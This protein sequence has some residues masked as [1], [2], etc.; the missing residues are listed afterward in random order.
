MLKT[1]EIES[2]RGLEK[3]EIQNL[4]R[5]N[6]ITGGNNFGKTSVL[7]ALY[8][9]LATP[10]QLNR[11]PRVFRNFQDSAQEQFSHYWLWLLPDRDRNRQAIVRASTPVAGKFCSTLSSKAIE[12]TTLDYRTERSIVIPNNVLLTATRNG[13]LGLHGFSLGGIEF[14]PSPIAHEGKKAFRIGPEGFQS[15]LAV[16]ADW[17]KKPDEEA[18]KYNGVVVSGGE[19]KLVELLRCV[20]PRLK[21]LRYAKITQQALIYADIGIRT[22]VLIPT[23]Q[24]GQ[25]FE[26]L[27]TLFIEM[28]TVKPKIVIIDE[29]ENGLHSS[30]Y[31]AVWLGIAQLA[32]SLDIQVF[33]TTHSKEC[34]H[35][36]HKASQTEDN[37]GFSNHRLRVESGKLI[38]RSSPHIL[39]MEI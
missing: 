22:N 5:I 17:R 21:K 15:C 16:F 39:G 33:A 28:L 32:R 6:V 19:D 35:A 2:F 37:L 7:E 26:R 29:V 38:V 4:S 23:S 25:A 30:V 11:L 10:D 9:L 36:A 12:D 27:L 14:T 1:I 3:I 18:E 31:E 24:M 20:E 8:F 34:L 13:T